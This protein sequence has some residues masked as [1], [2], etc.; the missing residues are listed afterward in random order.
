MSKD[1][2]TIRIGL[3]LGTLPFGTSRKEVRHYLGKPEEVEEELQGGDRVITWSYPSL[4]IDAYF[5]S[6]DNFRLG[7][8]RIDRRDAELCGVRIMGLPETELRLLFRDLGPFD[9]ELFRFS[10]HCPMRRFFFGDSNIDFWFTD[11]TLDSITWGPRI[12]KE[13]NLIWPRRK[14]LEKEPPGPR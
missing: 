12:D 11:G 4:G 5:S 6:E 14:F 3:G 2:K 8:L 9:D 7:S 1:I 10:D 13:D